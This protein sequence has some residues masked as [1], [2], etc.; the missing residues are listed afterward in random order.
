MQNIISC[1]HYYDLT[2]FFKWKSYEFAYL[3]YVTIKWTKLDIKLDISKTFL[4]E[5]TSYFVGKTVS[6]ILAI[7]KLWHVL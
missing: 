1:L 5:V 6:K 3:I 4:K 7:D 2:P